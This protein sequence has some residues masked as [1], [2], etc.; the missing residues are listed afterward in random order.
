MLCRLE[1]SGGLWNPVAVSEGSRPS[2]EELEQLLVVR[3]TQLAERDARIAELEQRLARLEHLLSRNSGNSSM[4][5][6]RDDDPGRTPL[7]VKPKPAA[8]KRKKGKQKGARGANLAW[9]EGLA[10]PRDRFPEGRCE[11]GLDL[12]GAVD[13]GV[14]DRYQQ[15]EIPAVTVTLTQYDQHEVRCGCG[16]THTAARPAGARSGPVGYGPNLQALSVYLLVAQHI[17]THRVVAL[18]AALTGTAPSVGFVHG[19]LARAAG[20][21]KA[22]DERVRALL[23]GAHVSLPPL[24][25][26]WST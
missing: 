23:T 18:L 14:V 9:I 25:T 13:L 5:P 17:P 3:D 10:D 4:P 8:G 22:V 2:Y 15:H 19:M 26:R 16:R 20:L 24:R 21:L 6:S 1:Y 12:A 11:C 7:A